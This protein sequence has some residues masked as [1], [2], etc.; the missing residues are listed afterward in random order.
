MQREYYK[1]PRRRGGGYSHLTLPVPQE[2]QTPWHMSQ[3][4]FMKGNGQVQ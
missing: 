3:G 4:V 2:C 1:T